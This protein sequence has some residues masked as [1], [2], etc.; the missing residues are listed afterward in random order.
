[1]KIKYWI[2]ALTYIAL[3]SPLPAQATQDLDLIFLYPGG[4]GS[5]EQ[6][7]PV[8]DQFSEALKTSSGGKLNPSAR[9]FTDTKAGENYIA[10]G[11]PAAGI[12]AEDLFLEKGKSWQAE[13]LL[14]TQMLPSGDGTNEYIV[15]GPAKSSLPTS[16]AITLISSRP[17]AGAF[18]KDQLFPDWKLT[19]Q[20]NAS[21]N[22]MGT[23]RKIGMGGE[24][25]YVLLD[26]FEFANVSRLRAAW[27]AGIQEL[28]RSAKISSAP[29]V[30]FSGRLNA[31]DQALLK[32]ALLKMG[33]NTQSKE[34]LGLLRLKGFQE[35]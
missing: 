13:P 17:L 2:V 9:Y 3:L 15:V 21:A 18:V 29:V 12:L 24:Q 11:K 19:V 28:A 26:Q 31:A 14:Q 1:M 27:V 16:G 35:K 33:K 22:V 20:V 8:L 32:S 34:V 10:S 30:V 23:L 7:Q 5:A 6:A 25:A 4:Q